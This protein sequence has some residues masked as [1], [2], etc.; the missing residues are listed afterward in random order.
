ME[1]IGE[2]K[3]DNTY[4]GTSPAGSGALAECI[5]VPMYQ[6][7]PVVRRSK[8]LQKTRKKSSSAPVAVSA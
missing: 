2:I 8:P 6:T 3:P 1:A 4:W 5:D 7:D